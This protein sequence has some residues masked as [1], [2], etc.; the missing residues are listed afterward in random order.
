MKLEFK[1]ASF[2]IIFAASVLSSSAQTTYVPE[3]NM[4]EIV[5][6][7]YVVLNL[8]G[9]R[10]WKSDEYLKIENCADA[11]EFAGLKVF[12]FNTTSGIPGSLPGTLTITFPEISGS[13]LYWAIVSQEGYPNLNFTFEISDGKISKAGLENKEYTF[14]YDAAGNITYACNNSWS[15]TADPKIM[16]KDFYYLRYSPVKNIV[17]IKKYESVG[18]K[19]DSDRAKQI[20]PNNLRY[21]AVEYDANNILKFVITRDFNSRYKEK[22][23][24]VLLSQVLNKYVW[25]EKSFVWST[26]DTKRIDIASQETFFENGRPVLIQ[27]QDSGKTYFR[28]EKMQYNDMGMILVKDKEVND[29]KNS[30][31][32]NISI[33]SNYE[34]ID[35]KPKEDI[36][37]YEVIYTITTYDKNKNI[38]EIKEEKGSKFRIKQ[39]DGS[40]SDWQFYKY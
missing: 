29:I 37:S 36:K 28:T 6:T 33:S 1:I 7:A 19:T 15:G 8:D 4:K 31:Y 11:K 26:T 10:V 32:E 13:K 39:P 40:W 20:F 12:K 35:G 2:A 3:A 23:Q 38:L 27:Y 24:I 17:E 16:I 22:A 30:K 34:L 14:D 18:K 5:K 25:K 9:F 21:T